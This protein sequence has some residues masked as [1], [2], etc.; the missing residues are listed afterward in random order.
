[1]NHG[2]TASTRLPAEVQKFAKDY[3]VTLPT[4]TLHRKVIGTKAA[5]LPEKA[6]EKVADLMSHSL[7]TQCRYYR[8]LQD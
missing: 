2:G 3:G 4:P 1:M 5:H 8:A 7:N 6:Q